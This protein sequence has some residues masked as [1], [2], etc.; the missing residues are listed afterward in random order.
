MFLFILV[1]LVTNCFL[2]QKLNLSENM[3]NNL[4]GKP[5]KE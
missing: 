2:Q 5:G 4:L 1:E 3:I